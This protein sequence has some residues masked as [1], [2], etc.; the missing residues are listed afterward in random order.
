MRWCFFLVFGFYEDLEGECCFGFNDL[1]IIEDWLLTFS[2]EMFFLEVDMI[3]VLNS[4]FE[5]FATTNQVPRKFLGG[6]GFRD[7]IAFD[8]HGMPNRAYYPNGNTNI[9]NQH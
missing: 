7:V 4:P 3:E 1:R 6:G 2:L 9:K 5:R 8:C